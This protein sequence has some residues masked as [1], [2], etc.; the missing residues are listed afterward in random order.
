[1]VRGYSSWIAF[2]GGN[3]AVSVM[4]TRHMSLDLA[5]ACEVFAERQTQPPVK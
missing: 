4:I 3:V 1:M 5:M 2:F